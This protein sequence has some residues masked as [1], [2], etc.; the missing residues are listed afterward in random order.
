M[1]LSV[2]R[3]EEITNAGLKRYAREHK[4]TFPV[5]RDT[6][7]M[8]FLQFTAQRRLPMIVLLNKNGRVDAPVQLGMNSQPE[9]YKANL[10]VRLNKLLTVRTEAEQ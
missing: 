10:R 8:V 5:L 9:S 6:A 4:L 1:R 3:P 2:E 7:E